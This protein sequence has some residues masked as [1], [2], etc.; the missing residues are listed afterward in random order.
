MDFPPGVKISIAAAALL[1]LWGAVDF[2]GFETGYQKQ[3]RDPYQIAAQAVRLEG[4][5]AAL[6]ANAEIGY[7][8]DL[9][10]GGVAASAMFNGAQYVL[11]PR[12]LHQAADQVLVLGNF[13]RP[14]D[15]AAI[16]RQHGLRVERDFQNGVVLFRKDSAR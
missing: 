7:L 16:G 9:E 2:F 11:A 15:F 10:P 5:R 12:L 3:N 4:V 1:A 8:T 6:P 14:G 13:S